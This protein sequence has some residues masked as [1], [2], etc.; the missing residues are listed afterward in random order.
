MRAG[1]LRTRVAFQTQSEEADGY[2]GVTVSW[3]TQA[4]VP[5]EFIATSGR[6]SLETGRIEESVTA[7]LRVR[8][9]AVP[10]VA[11]DWR[12]LIDSVPWNIRQVIPFGQRDRRVD[13]V[14]ERAG[15]GVAV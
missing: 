6:E 2:G 13:V 5:C 14:I 9:K 4:T 10:N 11:A 12:V 7:T 1:R 15:D 3:A 8:A